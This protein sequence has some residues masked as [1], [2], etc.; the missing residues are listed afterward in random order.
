[1]TS[2]GILIFAVAIARKQNDDVHGE[3]GVEQIRRTES[4]AGQAV[5]FVPYFSVR[6]C[7][8]GFS[9]RLQEGKSVTAEMHL[10]RIDVLAWPG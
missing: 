6:P 3:I 10:V 2:G 9:R 4:S 5:R 7:G 1:M 8:L